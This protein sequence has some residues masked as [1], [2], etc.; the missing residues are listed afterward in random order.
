[1]SGQRAKECVI[2]FVKLPVPGEV[3]TRL[4]EDTSPEGAARFYAVF[5]EEKLAE[6]KG[7]CAADIIVCFTPEAARAEVAEWLGPDH[8]YIAQKGADFGRRM[9]NAFREVFFMGYERAVLAGSDIPGLTPVILSD[10]LESLTPETACLGPAEDG[11]YYCIGFHKQGFTP[12]VFRNMEWSTP[13]VFQRTV[14]QFDALG[15]K[16]VELVQ[17]DDTDTLE[18]VETLVALGRSGPLGG[19]ALETAKKLTGM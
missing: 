19:K 17:L 14:N 11:G 4:A 1:M 8:R 2:F 6:L 16:W 7:G 5:A 3:K 13:E 10:A 9:E 15:R 18:D 12:E